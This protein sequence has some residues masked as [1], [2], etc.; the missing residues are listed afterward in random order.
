LVTISAIKP[1]S[2]NSWLYAK[3]L[4]G[5]KNFTGIDSPYEAPASPDI[6]ITGAEETPEQAAG[7]IVNWFLGYQTRK[8]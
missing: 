7:R 4:A 6:R 3:A 2:Q 1:F 5:I 8:L